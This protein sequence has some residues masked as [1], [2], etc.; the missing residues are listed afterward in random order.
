MRCVRTGVDHTNYV[1]EDRM[2][3]GGVYSTHPFDERFRGVLVTDQ[4]TKIVDKAPRTT[5]GLVL[6]VPV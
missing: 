2:P 3:F 1:L 4:N 6:G 5:V